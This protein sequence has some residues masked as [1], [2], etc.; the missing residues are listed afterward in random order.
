MLV[1]I[2]AIMGYNQ[3]S[4]YKR[5]NPPQ[6]N[7]QTTQ[8]VDIDYYNQ[9][10]VRQYHNAIAQLDGFVVQHW[11]F[12]RVDVRSP[13]KDNQATKAAVATYN[14]LLGTVKYYESKLV[15]SAGYKEAGLNNNQIK[16]L[17]ANGKNYKAKKATKKD[18]LRAL[19]KETP[20][21]FNFSVGA[22]GA[23]VYE[24]QLLLVANGYNLQ[25][26]GVFAAETVDALIAFEAEKSL[27]ADGVL[28][29]L[30]MHYLL[31]D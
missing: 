17:E 25:T 24:L 18:H 11:S 20:E 12:N 6:V 23:L 19:L 21:V 7:Y 2:V 16:A 31:A 14:E 30:T 22:Q 10:V 26:D 1:V 27:Y 9:E 5:F 28:D 15:A 4:K 13:K 8:Q 29:P 3:Y